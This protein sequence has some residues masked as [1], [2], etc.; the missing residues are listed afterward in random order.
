[1]YTDEFYNSTVVTQDHRIFLVG[2]EQ[3]FEFLLA[4]NQLKDR[5][6]MN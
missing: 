5:A 1:M 4:N 6:M 2:E 3:A